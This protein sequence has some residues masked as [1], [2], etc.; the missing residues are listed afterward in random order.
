MRP[1]IS[2]L[3]KKKHLVFTNRIWIISVFVTCYKTASTTLARSSLLIK[4]FSSCKKFETDLHL[5]IP[6]FL[7]IIVGS[8]LQQ[9]PKQLKKALL[10]FS[11]KYLLA[12]LFQKFEQFPNFSPSSNKYIAIY[13]RVEAAWYVSTWNY[14][15]VNVKVWTWAR[16]SVNVKVKMWKFCS[17]Q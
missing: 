7:F 1:S 11:S 6:F 9:A 2:N 10:V 8:V 4:I 14:E 13:V 3:K 12:L 15:S 17:G 5:E 16:E